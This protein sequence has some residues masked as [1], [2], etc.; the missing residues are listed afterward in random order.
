MTGKELELVSVT[1]PAYWA[2]YLING[3]DTIWGDSLED[4]A[5]KEACK[6]MEAE[7]GCCLFCEDFGFVWRPDYG[8]PGECSLYYFQAR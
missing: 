2:P 3:D 8:R 4:Q 1:A 7:L 5:D 6:A